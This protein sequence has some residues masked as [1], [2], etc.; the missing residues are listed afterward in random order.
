[1]VGC[2]RCSSATPESETKRRKLSQEIFWLTDTTAVNE[3]QVCTRRLL[4]QKFDFWSWLL[5]TDNNSLSKL[6]L[7][8]LIHW[9]CIFPPKSAIRPTITW[10]LRRLWPGVKMCCVLLSRVEKKPR[11]SPK[12]ENFTAKAFNY[13]I[14]SNIWQHFLTASKSLEKPA[15]F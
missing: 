4:T 9:W 7:S 10:A 3:K 12:L 11:I 13:A 5:P 2:N 15:H 8:R 6:W 14:K 1:M